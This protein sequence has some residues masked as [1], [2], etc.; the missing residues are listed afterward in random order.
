[1]VSPS[2]GDVVVIGD[3]WPYVGQAI[4]GIFW[5]NTKTPQGSCVLTYTSGLKQAEIYEGA[6]ASSTAM[7]STRGRT[8]AGMRASNDKR[9]G[10]GVR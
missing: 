9:H 4:V 10:R 8:D 6:T 2:A 3:K 7:A 5:G 1:M